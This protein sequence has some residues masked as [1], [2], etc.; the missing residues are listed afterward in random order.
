MTSTIRKLQS[1]WL[2]MAAVIV[3][4]AGLVAVLASTA[5]GQEETDI[6]G[7]ASITIADEEKVI[8]AGFSIRFSLTDP[9]IL[10]GSALVGQQGEF[11]LDL[12]PSCA[13]PEGDEEF[14]LDVVIVEFEAFTVTTT[15]TGP[16]TALEV[17]FELLPRELCCDR[18]YQDIG[19]A[20]TF[21]HAR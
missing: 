4:S 11:S 17:E 8:P 7:D 1:S 21:G 13:I 9:V 10:C 15:V 6:S 16:P 3:A 14:D 19:N 5:V 2:R 18:N 20:S 12:D